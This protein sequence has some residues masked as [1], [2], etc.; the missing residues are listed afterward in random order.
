MLSAAVSSYTILYA[1]L[2]SVHVRAREKRLKRIIAGLQLFQATDD[3]AM[4][5]KNCASL[6]ENVEYPG[7]LEIVKSYNR[8]APHDAQVDMTTC[9]TQA[10]FTKIIY[11]NLKRS[12]NKWLKIESILLLAYIKEDSSV[13]YLETTLKEKDHDISY[14]SM[15]SLGHIKTP[16][17]A[18]VLLNSIRDMRFSGYKIVSILETFPEDICGVI[19]KHA[20]SDD[21]L[22][23][24]WSIKLLSKFRPGI[25]CDQISAFTNDTSFNVRAAACEFLGEIKCA[26]NVPVIRKCLDDKNWVVRMYAFRAF[27]KLTGADCVP[28]GIKMLNDENWDLRQNVKRVLAKHVPDCIDIIKENLL[29]GSDTLRADLE[30]ILD[31]SGYLNAIFD[32]ILSEGPKE[33]N[34]A[35]LRVLIRAY[36]HRLVEHGI[37]KR[38]PEE[39]ENIINLI[40]SIDHAFCDRI[41]DRL[42][43][44][45]ELKGK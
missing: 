35:F 11:K 42:A 13:S 12:A 8:S 18:E 19:F 20:S 32:R 14:F 28:Y 15:I 2:R 10:G 29:S 33:E 7:L 43:Q 22:T 24:F 26:D 9:I 21:V 25:Y 30:E 37:F 41:K 45:K 36:A 39:Q 5:V 31:D 4:F 44:K 6:I 27:E 1:Y 3:K 17:S 38:P 23:R 40:N 34:L 16:A